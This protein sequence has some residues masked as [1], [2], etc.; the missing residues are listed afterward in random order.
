[1][2]K[3]ENKNALK[4]GAFSQALI[5]PGEDP[6][7]LQELVTALRDEWNPEGPSENDKIESIAICMWRKRRF[8][9]YL[10]NSLA[11]N[12][13]I[14]AALEQH[15]NRRFGTLLDLWEEIEESDLPGSVT[16]EN[17]TEKV[18]PFWADQFKT[19]RPRKNYDSDVAWLKAICEFV[20]AIQDQRF[21]KS[22]E[23][24]PLDEE[25]STEEFANREQD[26]E[27]RIDA[28]IDRDLK[29]LGQI[30]TMKAIGIGRR[31]PAIDVG[32]LKQIEAPSSQAAE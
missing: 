16:E 27:E 15:R 4:H 14:E 28:K 8:R 5:L 12:V 29:Q 19:R 25:L 22:D 24:P 30:K 20:K 21:T 10:R 31:P 23:L 2:S 9:T 32:S 6:N 1:M 18:G 26:F 17:P 3:S 7:D 13:R 11:K